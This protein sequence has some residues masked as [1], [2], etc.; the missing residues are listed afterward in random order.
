MLLLLLLGFLSGDGPPQRQ[1]ERGAIFVQACIYK[2][3]AAGA[4]EPPVG[5]RDGKVGR[6]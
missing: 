3:R 5:N 1:R 2:S 6:P 4:T